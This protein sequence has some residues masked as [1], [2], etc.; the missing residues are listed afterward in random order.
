M[1]NNRL[2]KRNPRAMHPFF[3]SPFLSTFWDEDFFNREAAPA[4]NNFMPAVN[5]SEDEKNWNIEVSAPGFKKEDFNVR[6][7]ND[8]L[9]ISA[10]MKE[11]KSDE[12]KN[13][14]TREFRSGSF[15]RSFRLDREFVDENGIKAAYENGILNITVPKS[16]K[17]SKPQAR[18]ISIG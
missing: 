17:A 6:L 8:V 1:N 14:R 18:E 12:Q 4:P 2:A 3:R 7:D 5:V 15:S 9:T 10:E 11:E 13:Y 16:E